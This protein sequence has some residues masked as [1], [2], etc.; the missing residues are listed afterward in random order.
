MILFEVLLI[1]ML[2]VDIL[3]KEIFLCKCL[4]GNAVNRNVYF[5]S[6]VLNKMLFIQY[7]YR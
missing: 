5:C 6:N 7:K 4:S 2:N 3:L 1:E